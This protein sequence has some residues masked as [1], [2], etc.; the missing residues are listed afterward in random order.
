VRTPVKSLLEGYGYTVL[1]ASDGEQAI[2]IFGRYAE[3]ID[4]AVLD[5]VMPK[6]SGRDVWVAIEKTRPDLKVLFISGH[7]A[8]SVH[9][10]FAPPSS[11]PFLSKPFSVIDLANKIRE[12]LD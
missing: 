2:D 10:D 11:L 1:T 4:L 12:I 3:Q 8:T 6:T 9:E 7:A 5:L